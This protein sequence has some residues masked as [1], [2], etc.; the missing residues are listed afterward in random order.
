VLAWKPADRPAGESRQGPLNMSSPDNKSYLSGLTTSF[1]PWGS[2]SATPKPGPRKDT[3]GPSGD[4]AV[5][6]NKVQDHTVSHR[7]RLFKNQYPK[8]CPPLAVQWYH[9]VDV[10]AT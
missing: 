7:R 8:D 10:S 5:P 2:R 6:A 3:D 1:S 9:A 4:L